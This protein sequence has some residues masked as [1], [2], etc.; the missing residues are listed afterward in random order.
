[1]SNGTSCPLPCLSFLVFIGID[2]APCIRRQR[3]PALLRS[4]RRERLSSRPSLLPNRILSTCCGGKASPPN[5]ASRHAPFDPGGQVVG[6]E[7]RCSSASSSIGPPCVGEAQTRFAQAQLEVGRLQQRQHQSCSSL[8]SLQADIHESA[9]E[10]QVNWQRPSSLSRQSFCRLKDC[11]DHASL[12]G[13]LA[14]RESVLSFLQ[15]SDS[16]FW[17]GR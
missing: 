13:N 5:W 12:K 10:L 1:M 4:T 17:Q 16:F 9:S 11:S 15:I 2:R 6:G 8:V 14:E 3:A 7:Q